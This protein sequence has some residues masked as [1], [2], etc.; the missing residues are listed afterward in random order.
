M[1]ENILIGLRYILKYLLVF[2]YIWKYFLLQAG[3]VQEC[4]VYSVGGP[5][6]SA[7]GWGGLDAGARIHQDNAQEQ[8]T[9]AL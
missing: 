5:G 6:T 1:F 9:D 3:S 4:E 8:G 7:G 2:C